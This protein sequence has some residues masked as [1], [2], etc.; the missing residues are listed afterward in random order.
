LD[1]YSIATQG[2]NSLDPWA[3]IAQGINYSIEIES[4]IEAPPQTYTGGGGG[5]GT[6]GK[7]L[8]PVVALPI[9]TDERPPA[10]RLLDNYSDTVK[11]VRENLIHKITVSVTIGDEVYTQ[12]VFSSKRNV[13]I[14]DISFTFEKPTVNVLL[15]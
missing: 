7:T 2:V 14:E 6:T 10:P 8:L 3:F 9:E 4:V 5:G 11:N 13:Y 1:T 12:Q 15:N